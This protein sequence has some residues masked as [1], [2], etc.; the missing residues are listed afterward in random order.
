MGDVETRIGYVQGARF[1][2]LQHE[3]DSVIVAARNGSL[4]KRQLK[5]R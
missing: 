1:I 3:M 2:A 4:P 5:Q